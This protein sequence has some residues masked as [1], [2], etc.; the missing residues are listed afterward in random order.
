[1]LPCAEDLG[2]VPGCVPK[3]LGELGI[4]GLRVLRWTREWGRPGDP[5]VELGDY[6]ALTVACPSVHDS[7]T[8]RE[9]YEREADRGQVWSLASRCLGRELGPAPE[10][11]TPEAAAVI[12]ELVARAASAVSVYPIQ[13]LLA[14]GE[15]F[16][17]P[18]PGAERINV[19]GNVNDW[20]WGWRL[21]ARLEEIAADEGLGS[22]ARKL[23]AARTA[24]P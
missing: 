10:R 18:E 21:P 9:W 17:L 13:D 15:A 1:M 3:V 12:L 4:M 16:R 8:T 7:S 5:Y 22:A 23:A 6:P 20:N 19:P 2:S 11:Y 14:L 24:K